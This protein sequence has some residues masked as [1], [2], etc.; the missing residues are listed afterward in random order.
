MT[1]EEFIS[2]TGQEPQH[3]DLDRVNCQLAGQIGH[4]QCGM[5]LIHNKPRFYCGCQVVKVGPA[6]AGIAASLIDP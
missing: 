2:A 5:C 1:R 3:D 4:K 6:T